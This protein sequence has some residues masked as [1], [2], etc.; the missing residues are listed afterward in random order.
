MTTREEAIKQ[1]AAIFALAEIELAERR[2]REAAKANP[3]REQPKP[4]KAG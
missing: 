4:R 2:A 3:E 1:A